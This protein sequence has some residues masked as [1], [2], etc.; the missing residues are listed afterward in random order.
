[1]Q[2]GFQMIFTTRATIE[3]ENLLR[4]LSAHDVSPSG[5]FPIGL[6]FVRRSEAP[7]SPVA[8]AFCYGRP[9]NTGVDVS[10]NIFFRLVI[11]RLVVVSLLPKF[12]VAGAFVR[13]NQINFLAYA[14]PNKTAQGAR[15]CLFNR[16]A[17][18]ISL[19]A[20]CADHG[21]LSRAASHMLFLFQWRFLS[22]PPM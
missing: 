1:M 4:V 8:S 13:G 19:P 12:V 22:L 5:T 20:D 18:H 3:M 14:L 21:G 11:H 16:S 6:V 15:I 2:M 7:S 17:N 9:E 10:P